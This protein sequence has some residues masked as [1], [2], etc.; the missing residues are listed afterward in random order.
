[1]RNPVTLFATRALDWFMPSAR[2]EA[3]FD[4]ARE[5]NAVARALRVQGCQARCGTAPLRLY[6]TIPW[7]YRLRMW[8][9]SARGAN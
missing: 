7:L 6:V 4:D 3:D 5:M 1:M 8:W 9:A 2:F